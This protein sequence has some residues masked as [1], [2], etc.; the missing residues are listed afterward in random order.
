MHITSQIQTQTYY[1]LQLNIPKNTN[2]YSTNQLIYFKTIATYC[3]TPHYKTLK[4]SNVKPMAKNP[5]PQKIKKTKKKIITPMYKTIIQTNMKVKRR[6][7][8]TNK[9]KNQ[10]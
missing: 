1:N 10:A 2:P 6:V 9:P 5:N 3:V 4:A 8:G 7:C